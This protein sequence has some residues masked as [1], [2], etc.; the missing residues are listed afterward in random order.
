M[1]DCTRCTSYDGGDDPLAL[2]ES[3]SAYEVGSNGSDCQRDYGG[4]DVGVRGGGGSSKGEAD[5]LG[6]SC[7]GVASFG[8]AE[9]GVSG[10]TVVDGSN[11]SSNGVD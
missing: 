8:I 1:N 7:E 4:D 11:G 2:L 9:I 10:G 3:A 5:D 6:G